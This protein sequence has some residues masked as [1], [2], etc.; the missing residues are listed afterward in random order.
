MN[1][2]E[3]R[4]ILAI[5]LLIVFVG[6]AIAYAFILLPTGAPTTPTDTKTQYE[7]DRPLSEYEEASFVQNGVVVVKYF[8]SSD[9]IDCET[10]SSQLTQLVQAL[11]GKVAVERLDLAEYKPLA[12][13][14]NVTD[15]PTLLLI[16]YG[17]NDRIDGYMEY[18]DLFVKVCTLYPYQVNECSL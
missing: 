2:D 1:R 17:R 12:D 11:P 6:S 4:Q 16:G 10:V 18:N 13:S 9:C 8:Q 14:L 3:K 5:F 7:Y 15:A